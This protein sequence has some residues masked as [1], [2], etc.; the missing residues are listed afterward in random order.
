MASVH[1]IIKQK[2]RF[3]DHIINNK[4][5][6]NV[7]LYFK[8][9]A[10]LHNQ[11]EKVLKSDAHLSEEILKRTKHQLHVENTFA[12]EAAEKGWFR[13]KVMFQSFSFNDL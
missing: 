2:Y 1:R 10:F 4:L 7:E 6:P 13:K 3:L 12:N 11:F 9:A 5:F 8:I